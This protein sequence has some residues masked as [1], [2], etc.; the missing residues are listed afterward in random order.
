[1]PSA[2]P[3]ATSYTI[4]HAAF[5]CTYGAYLRMQTHKI[6]NGIIVTPLSVGDVTLGEII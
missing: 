1:M 6:Y 3:L 4:F 2:P 5:E